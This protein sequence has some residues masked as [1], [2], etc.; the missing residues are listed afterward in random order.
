MSGGVRER[1]LGGGHAGPRLGLVAEVA[2]AQLQRGQRRQH[3]VG[4]GGQGHGADPQRRRP[5]LV[6]PGADEDAV[7]VAHRR[8]DRAGVDAPG[9][10]DRRHRVGGDRGVGEHVEP[11][12]GHARPQRAGRHR[13]AA[14][15]MVQSLLEDEPRGHAQGLGEVRGNGD[16]LEARAAVRDL[17]AAGHRHPL[18]LPAQEVVGVRVRGALAPL[19]RLPRARADRDHRHAQRRRQAL[20]GARHVEVDAPLVGA[21]VD[22]GDGRHG[23]E[24]EEGAGRAGDRA[25]LGRGIRGAR[26]RLVVHERDG[27]GPQALGLAGQAVEVEARAPL[28]RELDQVGAHAAHDL[29]HEHAEHPGPDDQHAVPRLDHR[30]RTRF[31]RGAARARHD[32][33][34][35]RRLEHLAQ[36]QCRRLQHGLVEGAVV[37]DGRRLV[38]RLDHRPRQL[39]GTGDHE[40]GAGV[41]LGPVQR[42]GHVVSPPGRKCGHSITPSDRPA[43][44]ASGG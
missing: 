28:G 2:Q 19:H 44:R 38:Q 9:H 3:V 12:G 20:L 13:V 21:D 10:F 26:R 5:D 31:Q 43:A 22:A 36:S 24:Q 34:L 23:V 14:E 8:D 11:H 1:L 29:S 6:E 42:R 18:F 15:A 27:L 4:A 25:D 37:L 7:A 33:H 16:R 35:A 39:G 41:Y 32:D 40:D 30:Q 17:A